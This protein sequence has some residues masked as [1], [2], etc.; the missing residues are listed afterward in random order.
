MNRLAVLGDPVS[1][2]LSPAIQ[3]AAF[4]ALGLDDQWRYEAIEV[5][6]EDF[7]VRVRALPGVGFIGA[8]VTIPHKRAALELADEASDA[9]LEIGAAN[10]LSFGERVTR[11]DN[12]DAPGFLAA[13]G[14]DPEG[15][16]ALVLGAGGSA[17]AVVWALARGGASVAIWNRTSDR[18]A[19]LAEE[20]GAQMH[21]PGTSDTLPSDEFDLVVNTTAVGLDPGAA[22][23][24][25]L[26]ALHIDPERLGA[27]QIV[28]DLAYSSRETA[29]VGAARSRGARVVDGL[30]MLVRQGAAAFRIWTGLEAPLD[31]M[32]AAARG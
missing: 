26:A 4:A 19:A 22:P 15:L 27:A 11:A 8:N 13:L 30:E 23:G 10:T 16:R 9:A 1:H 25:D 6:A 20:L 2:S 12:T 3:N 21:E 18:A 17:R 14:E 7:D 31:A 29:L 24:A 32:R 28:F 5:A